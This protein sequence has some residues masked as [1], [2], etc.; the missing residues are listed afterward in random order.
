MYF[1][2]FLCI[3]CNC[4]CAWFFNRP[5][6][7]LRDPV[8]SRSLSFLSFVPLLRHLLAF[9]GNLLVSAPQM[10]ITESYPASPPMCYL[11]P[12][13]GELMLGQHRQTSSARAAAMVVR[14]LV[15]LDVIRWNSDVQFNRPRARDGSLSF[16]PKNTSF[17]TR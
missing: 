5:Q 8:S 4:A 1:T 9:P 10:Y 16:P 15:S 13:T 2:Q 14:G 11:R 3:A 7:L 17:T 6:Y 12:T